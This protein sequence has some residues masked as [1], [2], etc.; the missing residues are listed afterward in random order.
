MVLV[1]WELLVRGTNCITGSPTV[2]AGGGGG[3]SGSPFAALGA[4]GTGGGG[5]GGQSTATC[6]T[7]ATV[8]TGGGGGGGS[9][10]G[11]T[12]GAG[13]SGVVIF[14]TPSTFPMAVSPG[15]NTVTTTP[16]GCYVAKFTVAGTNTLTI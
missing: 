15:T 12:G 14:R 7:S 4:G 13:G 16:G 2:Y 9:G 8:N 1:L 5:N 6:A 3:A 11:R 10:P